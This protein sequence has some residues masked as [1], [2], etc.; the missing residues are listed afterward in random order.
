MR[1]E[2]EKLKKKESIEER[3]DK[4]KSYGERMGVV[5]FHFVYGALHA[6]YIP[7]FCFIICKW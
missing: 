1:Y 5:S 6:H 2:E 7:I 4:K 3:E